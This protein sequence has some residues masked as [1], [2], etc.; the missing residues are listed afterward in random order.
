MDNP[1][2]NTNATAAEERPSFELRKRFLGQIFSIIYR[3]PDYEGNEEHYREKGFTIEVN[4]FNNSQTASQ[5][6][7]F[8]NTELDKL[9]RELDTKLAAAVKSV[10][11]NVATNSAHHNAPG[12][13]APS[14]DPA[15]PSAP[16][17]TIQNL[18]NQHGFKLN[19]AEMQALVQLRSNPQQFQVL[20]HQIKRN[21][22]AQ[23]QPSNSQPQPQPVQLTA[24]A[25]GVQQTGTGPMNKPNMP[26]AQPL[27]ATPTTAPSS[28]PTNP[29][30]NV[31]AAS[32]SNPPARPPTNPSN[33]NQSTQMI[34]AIARML[35]QE[36][37]P[38]GT[39][40]VLNGKEHHLSAE[41]AL[42][43]RN[44]ALLIQKI[45]AARAQ[46]AMGA[47]APRPPQ[48]AASQAM[49][50]A[51]LTQASPSL[52]AQQIQQLQ[53]QQRQQQQQ[54]QFAAAATQAP[55][56]PHFPTGSPAGNQLNQAGP[57]GA[58]PMEQP[59]PPASTQPTA[60]GQS[61][62]H[63]RC[64]VAPT[65][66]VAAE[67]NVT[68]NSFANTTA[69]A[70]AAFVRSMVQRAYQ[71]I[72][73]ARN[74]VELTAEQKSE[75]QS[76]LM[77]YIPVFKNVE[78]C[79]CALLRT[80]TRVGLQQL[81][82]QYAH[83]KR[84]AALLSEDVYILNPENTRAICMTVTAIVGKVWALIGKGRPTPVPQA[85]SNLRGS[86]ASTSHP[87]TSA[88]G[89]TPSTEPAKLNKAGKRGSGTGES[90]HQ[91]TRKK[92]GNLKQSTSPDKSPQVMPTTIKGETVLVK[93]ENQGKNAPGS[94]VSPRMPASTTAKAK[95]SRAKGSG[96]R[97]KKETAKSRATKKSTAT[98][99][100]QGPVAID[101]TGVPSAA[102][103]SQSETGTLPVQPPPAASFPGSGLDPNDPNKSPMGSTPLAASSSPANRKR[104]QE[105][106]K[107]KPTPTP[108]TMASG[109]GTTG[110]DN[111]DQSKWDRPVEYLFEKLDQFV[112]YAEEHPDDPGVMQV[113]EAF[114]NINSNRLDAWVYDENGLYDG[115]SSE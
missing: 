19:N 3:L 46:N 108:T 104:P 58:H 81:L 24:Q 10:Q 7:A 90:P 1:P 83:Y 80:P 84:Q 31:P 23:R 65:P 74:K 107:G 82:M 91:P 76:L 39:K 44:Q 101:L 51:T 60:T 56:R 78:E 71:G 79:L 34:L 16:H 113:I 33:T 75:V 43:I 27:G 20:F 95:A 21:Y 30:Q 22:L 38:E 96:A 49:P 18:A 68:G 25:V 92:S 88:I 2:P 32:A 105:K 63:E 55:Q 41:N 29:V 62:P 72:D 13:T 48:V 37:P 9:Q 12:A 85:L 73:T 14:A 70:L 42:Q 97:A 61:A 6:L 112:P 57:A 100:N 8:Q 86:V 11:D 115:Y 52:N 87:S 28:G 67:A 110:A 103:P 36:I 5:Y 54:Q 40:F 114:Q 66:S 4:S 47:N 35:P 111:A 50:A 15:N 102:A 99:K 53:Q 64:S 45:V 89:T 59:R 106:D 98:S 26:P 109:N 77:Q 94:Q 17:N 69:E 93:D